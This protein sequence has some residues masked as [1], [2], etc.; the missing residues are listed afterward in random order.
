[1]IT[2]K[3]INED[4]FISRNGG[5]VWRERGLWPCQWIYCPDV[6]SPPFVTAYRLQFSISK[7]ATISIHLTADER[8]DLF[9]NG[10]WVGRG[11]ERGD[12]N[13]WFYESYD[14]TLPA[15]TH[16]L[17]ARV[18][19]L[20]AQRAIAQ[21]SV[22]PGFLLCA[23]GEWL[24]Q[25]STGRAA[26]QVK[27]LTG[28]RFKTPVRTY[29]RGARIELDG[30]QF[31]WGYEKGA[32][33]GWQ[34]A[35]SGE[36]AV[37]RVVNYTW[38]DI[39]RLQPA[40]LPLMLDEE[41]CTGRVRHISEAES[42]MS[43]HPT[44]HLPNEQ[45]IWQTLLTNSQ[46]LISNPPI[47]IPPHTRRRILIDL[48][49]YYCLYPQLLVSGGAGSRIQLHSAES[50]Y[51]NPATDEKGHRD[52]IE[53]KLFAGVGDTFY[54]NGGDKRLFD[55]LWWQGGRYWE[56]TIETAVSPL[57]IHR[58]TLRE[59]RYPLEME[60]EF[61]AEDGR[62]QAIIPIMTRTVQMCS[63]ETYYDAPYYEELMYAGDTRLEMLITYIMNRDDRLPRKAI[64]M[65]DSSRVASGLTQA[66]YPSWETQVIPPFALYWVMML[67]DYAYWR[68]DATFVQQYLPGMRATLEAFQR[69]MDAD[70]LLSAPEGWNF[71]DWHPSWSAGIPPEALDGRSGMSNWLLVYTLTLAADLESKM[72]E[73]ELAQLWQ[74]RASELA[75]RAITA[76]WNESR[77]LLAEDESQQIFTEHSQILALLS[78]FLDE[79]RQSCIAAGLLT[80]PDLLRTTYYFSH[81]LFESYQL[82]GK[83]DAFLDRLQEWHI[84][85]KWGLKTTIER[86]EPT[87]SDCHAWAAH[88][89][90]HYFNTILGIRPGSLGFRTVEIRPQL[91]A[92]KWANGR[93]IHP[94]GA[95]KVDFRVD[96]ATFYAEI[97]LPEGVNGRLHLNNQTYVLTQQNQLCID[98]MSHTV[99]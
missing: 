51:L 31:P 94:N 78:G 11:S 39:H 62:L 30:S 69:F 92:L 60:S 72:G 3:I 16:M 73:P 79:E 26:W 52:E 55:T 50:L 17:V 99:L 1:M 5:K 74:R 18:S 48:D 64:R 66:R 86:P 44:D 15:G 65:Y 84:L 70:G 63:H 32:G 36:Q 14:L 12:A 33:D 8:Y 38:H 87:R 59:T 37:G 90:F 75:K 34:T 4:P 68:D 41:I 71:M 2:R 21:M 45:P 98:L 96:G 29:W 53:G 25:L 82:L 56:L 61:E 13:N 28:Y 88:P 91:G 57:T 20:G 77:G 43:Y 89:L 23:E 58:L 40:T 81:Y 10:K 49:D 35:V 47:S 83:T 19:A 7:E 46:S 95:I 27:K 67:R 42:E 85:P 9:L 24:D 80:A 76:Y 54:P 6:G 22:R 97:V 93:L